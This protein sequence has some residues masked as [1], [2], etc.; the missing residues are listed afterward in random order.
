MFY[1]VPRLC[2]RPLRFANLA[3]IAAIGWNLAILAGIILI[4]LGASQGREYAELPFAIDVIVVLALISMGIVVFATILGRKEKNFMYRC[5]TIW[6][7]CSGS[8]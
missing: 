3:K 4:L 7:P 8:P 5:G 2:R 6:A 1:I